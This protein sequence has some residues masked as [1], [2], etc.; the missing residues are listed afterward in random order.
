MARLVDLS[1]GSE[2]TG[3]ID[4]G[5]GFVDLGFFGVADGDGQAG[6]GGQ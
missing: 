2:G 6:K 3:S 4:A 1:A 5:E